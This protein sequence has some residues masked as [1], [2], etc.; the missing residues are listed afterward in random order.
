MDTPQEPPATRIVPFPTRTAPSSTGH[1]D[2]VD[3]P[4]EQGSSPA[5]TLDRL[6][7][8]RTLHD[9]V[10]GEQEGVSHL[11]AVQLGVSSGAFYPRVPTEGVIP[12]ASRLG[13]T[14]VE[15]MLQTPGEVAAEFVATLARQA[16]AAGIDVHAVHAMH[17]LYPMLNAYPRR[18]AEARE[19]FQRVI[20]AAV[21][22]GARVLVWHGAERKDLASPDGWERFLGLSHDLARACGAAGVTLGI[23][24]VSWC[25]LARVRDVVAFATRLEEIGGPREIGF[26]FDPFQAVEAGANP[27]MVLA[28][29]GNRVVDV[30]ISDHVSDNEADDPAARHLLP[31]DGELPWSALLRAI[32]G[33]GYA[34]PL[35][36]EGPLGTDGDGMDQ[37]RTLFA[38]LIRS[39][40]PFPP[41]ASRVS[42]D[43]A[44]EYGSAGPAT[45]PAGVLKGIALFN[46]R[47]FHAQHEEIE[48]E[49]HAERGPVRRLY[50]GMLQIGVGYHHALNGNYRGAVS[51]LADGIAK[52][53]SFTPRA[54]GIETGRLVARSQACLDQITALGPHRIAAFDPASIPTIELAAP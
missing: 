53:S 43:P 50:Q 2:A 26:V 34:G 54:M 23:E 22:L 33:S 28:A 11:R 27:F 15:L 20:E 1:H 9:P 18:A 5:E 49:W 16:R 4:E 45:P 35:M 40:F 47:R 17:H 10:P 24:N 25:A 13:V 21:T 48:H 32:S 3:A 42:D 38:P 31:G 19:G 39:V 44:A 6:L 52:T 41:D 51:L 30:H 14:A 7:A 36:I 29:M 37:V 12:A 46:Q 8:V